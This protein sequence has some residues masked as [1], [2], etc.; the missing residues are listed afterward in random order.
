MTD[1]KPDLVD[2]YQLSRQVSGLD[3]YFK[4]EASLK[5]KVQWA[6]RRAR[7]ALDRLDLEA[8]IAHA[9][10]QEQRSRGAVRAQSTYAKELRAMRPKRKK[11]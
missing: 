5:P 7:E 10:V 2:Y 4:G 9:E 3:P 1:E 11:L 8:Q 6:A